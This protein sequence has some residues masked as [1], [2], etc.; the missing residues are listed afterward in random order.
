MLL[1]LDQ[2]SKS[3]SA[4]A[5]GNKLEVLINIK[6]NIR[7]Q[8]RIA[9]VGPSGSGKSTLLNISGT[10]DRP[11]S[12]SLAFNGRDLLQLKETELASFRNNDIGFVFQLHYLLPQCTVLENVLIPTLPQKKN[13]ERRALTLLEQV[14]LKKHIHHRPGELSGGERQ[15]V[16]L[17]RA[18]INKPQLL[19][20]DEPT[21][22]LDADSSQELARL[23]I[24]LN[25]EEKMA[26]L[27]VTHSLELARL[28]DR[29]LLLKNG[30]LEAFKGS[31]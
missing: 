9:V 2:I 20:A 28:M 8:E 29:I 31:V 25:A 16:A 30:R 1:Q 7:Q 24:T 15:R 5:G 14:G 18:L 4:P 19:L 10:L 13:S 12:G 3:Y 17:V 23:L 26:L 27:I 11:D 21:G 6:L 22:S